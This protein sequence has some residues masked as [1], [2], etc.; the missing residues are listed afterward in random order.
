MEE[1]EEMDGRR[2]SRRMGEQA[3]GGGAPYE[4]E[5]STNYGVWWGNPLIAVSSAPHDTWDTNGMARDSGVARV[6]PVPTSARGIHQQAATTRKTKGEQAPYQ[7]EGGE[8][9]PP[10]RP[11][12]DVQEGAFHTALGQGWPPRG[13]ER[14][15]AQEER[16]GREEGGGT[17]RPSEG[18]K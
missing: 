11:Q 1:E 6:R 5:V 13:E 16:D 7:A 2:R 3:S 17:K 9:P 14:P 15:T 10:R 4:S 12:A 8:S 18:V